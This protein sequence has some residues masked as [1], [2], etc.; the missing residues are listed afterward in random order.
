MNLL[1]VQ[2][3]HYRSRSDRT[4][5]K[6]RKR[7]L[8]SLPAF[9]KENKVP[10]AYFNVLTPHKGTPLYDRMKRE[11]RI[12]DIDHIGR[13]PGIIC[14]IRPEYCSARELEAFVKRM[15]RGFYNYPSMFSRLSLPLTKARIAS[16]V[17]NLSQRKVA[18]TRG[19]MEDFDAY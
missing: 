15:Y 16:W 4:L 1:I 7:T 8:V 3:S 5:H 2:P 10:A 6:T 18:H 9:L 12:I 19:A 14:Y 13:W 17:V 11:N